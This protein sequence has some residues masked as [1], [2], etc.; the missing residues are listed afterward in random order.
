LQLSIVA[1]GAEDGKV[2]IWKVE[3]SAFEGWGHGLP[4]Q[5]NVLEPT[6]LLRVSRRSPRRIW[7]PVKCEIDEKLNGTPIQ[8][9]PRRFGGL[10][11]EFKL[12]ALENESLRKERD[13]Y[14][15]KGT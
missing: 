13:G 9:L 11:G 8:Y 4:T 3:S 10:K 15:E 2:M 5:G 12:I 1:S 7:A 14:R 6:A